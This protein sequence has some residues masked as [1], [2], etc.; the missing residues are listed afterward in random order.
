MKK[1]GFEVRENQNMTEVENAYSTACWYSFLFQ[2]CF[3]DQS[4]CNAPI[5]NIHIIQVFV[6]CMHDFYKYA[7]VYVWTCTKYQL[8]LLKAKHAE[9]KIQQ[10]FWKIFKFF[11]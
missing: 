11:S 4:I 2:Y 7:H 6:I 5:H 3:Y 1:G 10:T 8:W 9:K